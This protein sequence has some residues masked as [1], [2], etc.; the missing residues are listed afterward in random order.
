MMGGTTLR[1]LRTVGRRPIYFEHLAI[2]PCR[3]SSS[4]SILFIDQSRALERG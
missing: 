1:V 3:A 4:P 2:A